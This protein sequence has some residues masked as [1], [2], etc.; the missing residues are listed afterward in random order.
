MNEPTI[1]N[2]VQRLDRVE[3]ENRRW[4]RAGTTVLAALAALVLMGQ[5]KPD[6]VAEV[7][8]AEK[9]VLRDKTGKLRAT[10]AIAA[11]GVVS[12]SLTGTTEKPGAVLAAARDGAST[13]I[14]YNK[15]GNVLFRAP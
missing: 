7:V 12:L 5:A 6:K 15:D 2:L 11:D 3:R 9:F 4:K 10:L 13:L 14:L 8:E 1:D